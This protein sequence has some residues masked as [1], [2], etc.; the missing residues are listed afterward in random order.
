MPLDTEHFS[1]FCICKKFLKTLILQVAALWNHGRIVVGMG[2]WTIL[3]PR[4]H[5]QRFWLNLSGCSL[6]TQILKSCPGDSNVHESLRLSF[7][8]EARCNAVLLVLQLFSGMQAGLTGDWLV[9][10]TSV[11][12]L[13]WQMKTYL[14]PHLKCPSC[15]FLH[16]ATLAPLETA[17]KGEC[18]LLS[19]SLLP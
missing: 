17:E 2:A 14:N 10:L 4:S 15:T 9:S 16:C 12:I 13:T 11:D 5:L 18:C 3:M 8:G 1:Q 19:L 6:D 7:L